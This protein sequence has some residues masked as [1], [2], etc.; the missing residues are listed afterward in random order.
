M[1][2]SVEMAAVSKKT[3]FHIALSIALF[4]FFKFSLK[5]LVWVPCG[6]S[7]LV[8][9]LNNRKKPDLESPFP[10]LSNGIYVCKIPLG[11]GAEGFTRW[12]TD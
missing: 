5:P 4:I 2:I 7:V 1:Q 3:Q 12:P 8:Q 11:V 6:I 10:K 9:Q